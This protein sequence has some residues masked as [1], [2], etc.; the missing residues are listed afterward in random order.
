MAHH[1]PG[2]EP[3]GGRV[4]GPDLASL[5]PELTAIARKASDAVMRIYRGGHTV[6]RK[7]DAS[8]VTEADHASEA[9]ILDGLRRLTPGIPI[10]SEEEV[11]KHGTR[12]DFAR[13]PRQYWLVDPVD[14]TKEFVAKRGEFTINIGLVQDG[15]PALGVLHAPVSGATYVAT[16]SGSATVRHGDAPAAPIHVRPP[17]S[18]GI[19]V[20]ASRS[21][22]DK[23]GVSAFLED[24]TVAER[25]LMGS[26]I[27]FAL[28]AEGTGDLYPRLG[29][30]MEWDTCA[31]QA[32]L[33]AAGGSVATLSGKPLRYGKKD[34]L[35][36]DFVAR[37]GTS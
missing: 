36:P 21:H 19:I 9:I 24:Y 7:A 10:I 28:I 16:G 13:P 30:T 11:A 1:Q 18:S 15:A 23:E 37:G 8:P 4:S 14:G 20:L 25:R 17:P 6:M 3:A 31:G 27:K 26:A 29:P 32:I 34:F 2:A 33:E 12:F 22:G 5:L 35:N